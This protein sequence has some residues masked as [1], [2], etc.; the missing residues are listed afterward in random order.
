MPTAKVGDINMYYEVHGEGEPLLLI[1]GLGG[2]LTGWIFQIIEF[3]KKYRVIV[4]DNRGAGRTDAPDVPY[5]IEMMADDTA[6]LLDVLGI[7][8]AHI[9]GLSMGGFIAQELALKYPQRV[10]SLILAT[11][12]ASPHSSNKHVLDTWAR[13]ALEGVSVET[14]L[15]EQLLWIFTDKFFENPELVQM[16]INTM[17]ANPQPQPTYAFARQVTA[18]VEHDTRDRLG[19]ITAPTLVLVGKE[20]ILL[21]VKLSEELA[22]GIPNAE[23]VV[24]EGGGHG[25]L[26][27]IADKFNQAVL[28][29]L[30]KTEKK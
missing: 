4:F 21:P 7:E 22:V 30:A 26:A 10:Q 5:S 16:A 28:D 14:R 23:L 29:Y 18:C 1:T 15:R 12:A 2:D 19:E 6:G 24:L 3:S 8:R 9:L 20:D 17:L 13:M 11:T 25:F 27:E